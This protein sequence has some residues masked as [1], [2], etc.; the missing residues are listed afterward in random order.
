MI[1]DFAVAQGAS[2]LQI[3][4]LEEAGRARE[5]LPGQAPDEFEIAFAWV[6]ASRLREAL[7]GRLRI[8]LDLLDRAALRVGLA[9]PTLTGASGLE[10]LAG[11]VERAYGPEEPR[12]LADLVAPLVVEADGTVVPMQYGFPRTYSLGSL[13]EARLRFLAVRWRVQRQ[14]A[15]TDLCRRTLEELAVPAELPFV[16]W[17]EE[18]ARRAVA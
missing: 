8:H 11:P 14:R 13:E 16:N 3:H 1:A 6:V 18:V 10:P 2:L 4:P 5:A 7:R 15:F 9:S 12:R 17:Y